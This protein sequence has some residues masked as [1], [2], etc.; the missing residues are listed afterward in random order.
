VC[1]RT[2][3]EKTKGEDSSML[4][5]N[6]CHQKSYARYLDDKVGT[7]R[8]AVFGEAGMF[9]AQLAGPNQAPMGINAP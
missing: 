1:S 3:E 7:G 6:A 9:S 8:V 5:G 4:E 2:A